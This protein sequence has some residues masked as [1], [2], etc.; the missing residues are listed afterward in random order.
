[1]IRAVIIDDEPLAVEVLDRFLNLYPDLEVVGKFTNPVMA[2]DKISDLLCDVIFL[3][4]DMP[5]IDGLSF[6]QKI[7]SLENRPYI[8][9]VTAHRDYML[10]ALRAHAFDFLL[11]P[12]VQDVLTDCLNRIDLAIVGEIKNRHYGDKSV[13]DKPIK[14]NSRTGF[15]IFKPRE[16]IA[17]EAEGSY[18]SVILPFDK[19]LFSYNLKKIESFLPGRYLLRI[20]RS[21][22]INPQYFRS[23]DKKKG[24]VLLVCGD[25]KFEVPISQNFIPVIEN[26]FEN[27]PTNL[28][29]HSEA[30]D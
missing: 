11:K 27:D 15:V 9:F 19:I 16:I 13:L 22:F 7:E 25:R 8:V 5:G 12:V 6:A 2:L 17:I 29:S 21:A 10:D 1:M 30:F 24:V 26:F 3:D 18:C 23:L 20:S 28:S 4:I 14:I